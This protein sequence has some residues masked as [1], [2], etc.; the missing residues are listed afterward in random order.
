MKISKKWKNGW[1]NCL[2]RVEVKNMF[3][4]FTALPGKNYELDKKVFK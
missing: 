2:S 4:H 1:N 3:F